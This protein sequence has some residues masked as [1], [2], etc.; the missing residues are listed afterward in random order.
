VSN[1]RLIVT[2]HAP[3]LD[4]ITAVWL[5]KHFVAQDYADARIAFVNPGN[6]ITLQQAQE[7]GAQLHEVT[8]TDT[9]FGE[10]DH[11]QPER[12]KQRVCATSLVY[13]HACS[14]H[15]ELRDDEAL[16][17]LVEHVN[18]VD[19]FEEIYWPESSTPRNIFTIQE[20][21]KGCELTDPHDD[22]SQLYFGF[23]CLEKAYAALGQHVKAK[24]IIV[25]DGREFLIK[26][27]KCLA[28]ETSNDETI[29]VAQKLGYQ[30]VIRRDPKL[31]IIRIKV[32][33]DA[34]LNLDVLADKVKQIDTEASWFYHGS[35]KMLLNGSTKDRDQHPSK[36]SLEQVTALI[37]ELYG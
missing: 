26:A 8:H 29:K 16:Q 13:E 6:T 12:A 34:Q 20:L 2:H 22:E 28:I 35:G 18:Q 27:G 36:L 10:F 4:A 1:R 23:S 14:I 15:P 31:G 33:P 7:Y 11:H 19:H 25:D 21:I 17:I 3:D 9:G 32:R 30:L 37:Q 24:N 5:L